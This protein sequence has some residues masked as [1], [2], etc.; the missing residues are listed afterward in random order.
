MFILREFSYFVF[1]IFTIALLCLPSEIVTA[2]DLPVRH[3]GSILLNTNTLK[4]VIFVLYFWQTYWSFASP[5]NLGKVKV[6]LMVNL[7]EVKA[8]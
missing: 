4:N 3:R 6:K 1:C 7:H 5:V 2:N 8:C